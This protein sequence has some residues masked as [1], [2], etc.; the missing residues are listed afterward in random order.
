VIIEVGVLLG[1]VGTTEVR[2]AFSGTLEG[3]LVLAGER[4]TGGQPIAW[5]RARAHDERTS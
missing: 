1:L 2:S 4:V 5:L 3:V